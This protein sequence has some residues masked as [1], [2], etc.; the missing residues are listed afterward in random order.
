MARYEHLPLFKSAYDFD[1]YFVKL[2]KGFSKDFKYGIA[3]EIRELILS[4]IDNIILANN[5]KIKNEY[6]KNISVAIE[7]I[8]VKVRLLKDLNAI[9]LKSYK[10]ISEKLVGISKQTAAWEKW[11]GAVN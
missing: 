3:V 5:N 11:S 2:S 4:I 6:L 8:K 7:R 1:L 10:Y 9:S